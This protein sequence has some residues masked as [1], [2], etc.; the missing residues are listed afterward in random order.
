MKIT[1]NKSEI[2]EE[3]RKVIEQKTG[4]DISTEDCTL[5]VSDSCGSVGDYIEVEF[6]AHK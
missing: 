2:I 4:L 3:L 1:L 6:E 5:N